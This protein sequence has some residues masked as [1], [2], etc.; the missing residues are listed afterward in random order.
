MYL[1]VRLLL[2]I[3]KCQKQRKLGTIKDLENFTMKAMYV[4]ILDVGTSGYT[5]FTID[6][7]IVEA[8]QEFPDAKNCKTG[9]IH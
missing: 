8:F 7:R 4:H 6:G 9:M 3:S 5:E 2:L 1:K